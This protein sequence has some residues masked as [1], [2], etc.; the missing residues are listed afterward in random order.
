[1][2]N[3]RSFTAP[4]ICFSL[5]GAAFLLAAGCQDA[6]SGDRTTE[7]SHVSDGAQQVATCDLTEVATSSGSPDALFSLITDLDVD[8]QGEIYVGDR[9]KGITVLSDDGAVLRRIGR[10]G[11]GPGEFK[12]IGNVRILP[13]DSLM[14]YD[15]GLNR[16]TVFLPKSGE[17]AYVTN[18]AAASPLEPPFSAEKIPGQRAILATYR[19]AYRASDDPAE[20]QNRKQVLRLLNADGSVLRD[21]VL[22]IPGNQNLVVRRGGIISSAGEH[23]F[24]S[25]PVVEVGSDG[26]IYYGSTDSLAIGIFSLQGKRV[27]G[28][29][30]PYESAPITDEDV[31]DIYAA[32]EESWA[33][34][35][36]R[37]L[38]ESTPETWPAF[39]NFVVDDRG[40]IWVGLLTPTG[41]PTEWVAF[42]D[43]GTRV[44]SATLP[45]SVE[46]KLVRDGKAYA[47][48]TDELDVPRVVVYRIDEQEARE[49]VS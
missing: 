2:G 35:F 15:F 27:G 46:I 26:R 28:F 11:E 47:V 22:V 43:S 42:D 10:E 5:I 31:E 38:E 1:M 17:V 20:D 32:H 8:S 30:A 21:S 16:V 3:W 24:R 7:A 34:T 4:R 23:P 14:V 36:G 45:E 33:S 41:Q 6:D 44:C 19:Q 48:A 13:G 39:K 18:L 29:S 12:W 25:R 49:A 40:R 9:D 37:A